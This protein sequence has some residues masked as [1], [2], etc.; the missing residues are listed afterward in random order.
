MTTSTSSTVMPRTLVASLALLSAVARELFTPI[1]VVEEG[2]LMRLA[3]SCNADIRQMLNL[4]Q[5]WR[6]RDGSALTA[7]P[8][9]WQ[10]H[11]PRGSE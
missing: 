7:K 9:S 8:I 2:T 1:T 11:V 6:P 4:L 10:L 5:I 3:E